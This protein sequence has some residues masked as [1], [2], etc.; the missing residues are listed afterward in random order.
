[1][2]ILATNTPTEKSTLLALE[3][4]EH[5]HNDQTQAYELMGKSIDELVK[6]TE[7]GMLVHTLTKISE[8]DN[9]TLY[10]W[11]EVFDGEKALEAHLNNPHVISHIEAMNNGVL[12][13]PTDIVIYADW[14]EAVKEHWRKTLAGANLTFAAMITG[15]FV[16][17]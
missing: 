17:R 9:E 7:P 5:V 15:F 2:T 13:G 10:R 4:F 16:T 3:A 6:D 12:S 14:S 11:L 8:N 1:M